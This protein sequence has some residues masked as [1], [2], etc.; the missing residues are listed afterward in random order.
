MLLHPTSLLRSTQSLIPFPNSLQL[1]HQRPP[2]RI[3]AHGKVMLPIRINIMH[4]QR[5]ARITR[6]IARLRTR[7]CES[8]LI[9]PC[10]CQ[11]DFRAR[12]AA[13][14]RFGACVGGTAAAFGGVLPV[15]FVH[16][17]SGFVECGWGE[18]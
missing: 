15:R 6:R 3:L 2:I 17:R 10:W 12:R 7:E 18:G 14:A 8:Q 1:P 13:T 9:R 4:P 5:R 11:A 16:V